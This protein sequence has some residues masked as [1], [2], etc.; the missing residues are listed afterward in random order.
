M[1]KSDEE[2]IIEQIQRA[3]K[4]TREF[5]ASLF[6]LALVHEFRHWRGYVDRM[7]DAANL[8]LASKDRVAAK[9]AVDMVNKFFHGKTREDL[10][11]V[12]DESVE[13]LLTWVGERETTA[14]TI[15]N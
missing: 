1:A 5:E 10:E 7:P 8:P 14:P 11:A 3:H 4:E 9:T 6:Q 2:T 13:R 12:R 15:V